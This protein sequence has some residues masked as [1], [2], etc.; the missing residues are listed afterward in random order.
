MGRLICMI[1]PA[2]VAE[3]DARMKAAML[4]PALGLK[5][6]P[7]PR[8][9]YAG[10][11]RHED[12]G[13]GY[14]S[15]QGR[16]SRSGREGLFDDVVGKGWQLLMRGKHGRVVLGPATLEFLKQIHAAVADFGLNG[17]TVDP[18]G[19]YAD[20]FDRLGVDAVLVRPDLYVFGSCSIAGVDDLVAAAGQALSMPGRAPA[21]AEQ[22]G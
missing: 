10:A 3:R 6:P 5:P 19:T 16:V 1:D 4:D 18:D 17:D 22:A 2:Q 13:S 9:G 15:V 14:L 7:E 12:A 20:W 21:L 11:F 8:L